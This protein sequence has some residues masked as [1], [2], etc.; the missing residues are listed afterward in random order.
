MLS[1]GTGVSGGVD[2]AVWGGVGFVV[3]M[4]GALLE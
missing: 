2:T 3:R 4:N 1:S